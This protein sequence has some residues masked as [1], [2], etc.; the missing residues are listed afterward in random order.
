[1]NFGKVFDEVILKK[2]TSEIYIRK[3]FS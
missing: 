2:T 1:L 3:K